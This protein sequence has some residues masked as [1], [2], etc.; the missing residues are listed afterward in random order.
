[1]LQAA[2]AWRSVSG[3][4]HALPQQAYPLMLPPS[5]L[6]GPALAALGVAL[7]KKL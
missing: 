3:D 2:R 6:L 7:S 4:M 5:W 1:M